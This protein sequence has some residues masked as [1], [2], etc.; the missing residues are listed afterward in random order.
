MS[1]LTTAIVISWLV[2]VMCG[3]GI[4]QT[5]FTGCDGSMQLEQP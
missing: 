1:R 2:G 3:V 5:L 4:S